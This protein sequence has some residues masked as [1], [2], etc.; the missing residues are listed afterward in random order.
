MVFSKK[1]QARSFG[2]AE[3]E[4]I[5]KFVLFGFKGCKMGKMKVMK[6]AALYCKAATAGS[7]L[8][9]NSLGCLQG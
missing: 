2:E 4:S 3:S 6:L 5:G 9:T 7:R 8:V 1:I